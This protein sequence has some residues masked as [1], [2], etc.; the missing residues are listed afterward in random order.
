MLLITSSETFQTPTEDGLLKCFL[1]LYFLIK[2]SIFIT[3]LLENLRFLDSVRKL[4]SLLL[5]PWQRLSLWR[6]KP[7]GEGLIHSQLVDHKMLT[8]VGGPNYSMSPDSSLSR[9]KIIKLVWLLMSI[10]A[11]C[12]LV[13]MMF[14]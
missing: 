14:I 2:C 10:L 1:L 11:I 8:C 7:V 3:C 5:F 6:R 9:Q 13:F 4:I 12:F